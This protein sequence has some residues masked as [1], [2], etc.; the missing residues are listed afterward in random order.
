MLNV[1]N[2]AETGKPQRTFYYDKNCRMNIMHIQVREIRGLFC[3]GIKFLPVA[4]KLANEHEE[5][6]VSVRQSDF[7]EAWQPGNPARLS[8]TPRSLRSLKPL[9]PEFILALN[10]ETKEEVDRIHSL[11]SN[12]SDNTMK[13]KEVDQKD[14]VTS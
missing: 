4:R 10:I 2:S 9:S 7:G 13:K 5:I 3:Y 1:V 14:L 8:L 12:A 11:L 6:R